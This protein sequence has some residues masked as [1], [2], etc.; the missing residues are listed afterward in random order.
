MHLNKYETILWDWNGTLI[1]DAW[2][3]L[4]INNQLLRK[5]QLPPFTQEQYKKIFDFPIVNYY[6]KLGFDLEA[7]PFEVIAQEFIVQYEARR[8][9]CNLHEG[10]ESILAKFNHMGLK[11][12]I[13]SATHIDSLKPFVDRYQLTPYFTHILGLDNHYAASKVQVGLDWLQETSVD[14]QK[15]LLIGDTLHDYEVATALG[16]DCIVIANG[17]QD[18]IRLKASGAKVVDSLLEFEDYLS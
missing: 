7:E 1:N 12:N 17:H 16:A 18:K 8:L 10:A 3:S 11:Q 15:I 9:E 4:D 6:I 13:L 5:R 14:P 2:L